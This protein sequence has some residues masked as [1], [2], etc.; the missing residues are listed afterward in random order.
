MNNEQLDTI[1]KIR[2]AVNQ[3]YEQTNL[4]L[5]DKKKGVK[6]TYKELNPSTLIEEHLEYII[7]H[8]NELRDSGDNN[9]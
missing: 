4:T 6:V 7:R 2:R 1:E 5:Y 3:L 9:G 8:L